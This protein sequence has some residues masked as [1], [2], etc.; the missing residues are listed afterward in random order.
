[1]HQFQQVWPGKYIKSTWS[2][3]NQDLIKH[4]NNLRSCPVLAFS[5]IC[6]NMVSFTR[7]VPLFL[8]MCKVDS[9]VGCSAVLHFPSHHTAQPTWAH[10][11]DK[12]LCIALEGKQRWCP[13]PQHQPYSQTSGSF[14]SASTLLK[15]PW[16]LRGRVRLGSG[17][18]KALAISQRITLN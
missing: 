7:S 18:V 2:C 1:M 16:V 14:L 13:T 5:K 4:L 11:M 8:R 10:C 9:G 3:M 6:S 17:H 12:E 15:Q